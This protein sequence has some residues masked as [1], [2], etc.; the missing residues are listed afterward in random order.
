MPPMKRQSTRTDRP[1]SEVYSKASI[2]SSRKILPHSFRTCSKKTCQSPTRRKRHSHQASGRARDWPPSTLRTI[3]S[4]PPPQSAKFHRTSRL[5]MVNTLKRRHWLKIQNKPSPIGIMIIRW[6][7]LSN[8]KVRP[9]P[10]WG[11]KS[12][13]TSCSHSSTRSGRCSAVRTYP[14]EA[15]RWSTWTQSPLPMALSRSQGC[16]FWGW[17]WRPSWW[18]HIWAT[19]IC[20]TS[21]S[22]KPH[23]LQCET[24]TQRRTDLMLTPTLSNHN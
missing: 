5:C 18:V 22:E 17:I 3:A 7:W 11:P 20:P 19:K 16:E 12:W 1:C 14:M 6:W 23:F 2:D 24:L 8:V 4:Q 10:C 21:L 13:P 9:P 15:G